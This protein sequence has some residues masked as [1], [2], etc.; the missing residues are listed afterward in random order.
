MFWLSSIGATLI[1]VTL[2]AALLAQQ[3]R[4]RT[5]SIE[6]LQHHQTNS[7]YLQKIPLQLQQDAVL[8]AQ[9][10]HANSTIRQGVLNAAES[11]RLAGGRQKRLPQYGSSYC[12]SC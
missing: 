1:L 5:F 11:Y 6:L 10:V 4:N 3:Q 9:L 2:L 12:L 8:A 7:Q